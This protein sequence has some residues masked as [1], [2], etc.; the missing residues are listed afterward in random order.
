[1]LGIL[2]LDKKKTF[3]QRVPFEKRKAEAQ[4][5][6]A[7]YPDRIP[8]IVEKNPKSDIPDL[9]KN[10]YLVPSDISVG[11]FMYIIRSR[12]KLQ[13]EKAIFMFIND[14]TLPPTSETMGQLYKEH[15]DL[16]NF[17]YATISGESTFGSN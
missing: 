14:K 1:M 16:D 12:V 3:K 2:G 9:D 6:R 15:R 11:Q 4:R 5:I 17:L 7:K 10:R 8:V 13:P